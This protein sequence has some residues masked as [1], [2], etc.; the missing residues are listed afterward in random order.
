MKY[1]YFKLKSFPHYSETFIVQNLLYSKNKYNIKI[2]VD[3]LLSFDN[4]SQKDILEKNNI[5]NDIV[6]PFIFSKNKV[7]KILEI[8]K[9]LSNFKILKFFLKY[10]MHK[11]KI[12]FKYLIDLKQFK[13]FESEIIHVHFNNS[14]KP[15]PDLT[16]I[17]Y[18]NPKC[19]ITFHGF[20]AF[21]AT[22]NDFK[23][24]F[25]IFYKSNVVAVTVNSNY[26]KKRIIKLG[27]NPKS[28]YVIPIGINTKFFTSKPKIFKSN[29]KIKLISV[30]R[31]IQLKGH[32]Y[33]IKAL[34]LLI[35]ENINIEYT[36]IGEGYYSDYLINLVKKYNLQK[37]VKFRGKLN[38][39][40]IVNELDKSHIFIMPSTYDEITKRR[41]AFG[42][43]SIEAQAMGLPVIGF[44][45]GGFPDTII[46]NKTGFVVRDRDFKELSKKI[47][48]F[49]NNPNL[50]KIFSKNSIEHAKKF[51]LDKTYQKYHDIYDKFKD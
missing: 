6:K 10:C 9:L 35:I 29:K 2:I 43:V 3:K 4:S 48:F 16:C 26:L 39:H 22:P 21:L 44:N 32:E 11:K 17:G 24:K 37:N 20:D 27:V 19:I 50:Y 8:L 14:L 15:I 31:L 46:D 13:N 49:I 42:L 18:I 7:K 40:D 38:Q 33:A 1:I 12:S 51:N 25:E 47:L 30:G 34:K 41:E 28:I 45:S 5:I 23:K 36:I